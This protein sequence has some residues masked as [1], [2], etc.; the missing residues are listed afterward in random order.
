MK[1]LKV[2]GVLLV[3]LLAALTTGLRAQPLQE[4]ETV[5][6]PIGRDAPPTETAQ[7]GLMWFTNQADFEAFVARQGK[8]L[9]GIEDFEES[10]L[11]PNSAD[12]FD[13]PLE[14]GVANAPDGFPF[15]EGMTGLPNLK[16]QSNFEHDLFNPN[17]PRGVNALAA[18][19]ATAGNFVSDVVIANFTVDS[20][21]LIFTGEETA[22]GFN[23]LRFTSPGAME[24]N[25]FSTTNELLGEMASNSDPAG[26]NFIGVWSPIPIGRINLFDVSNGHEGADRIQAWGAAPPCPAD[27]DDSGDVGV[28]DLLFLLGAWGPCP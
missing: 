21:D 2:I 8:V 4:Q 3:C 28:K 7:G 16:V 1:Q 26:T 10:I 15:P 14:S 6:P 9:K 23:T 12:P 17:N 13:D 25:V 27:F 11:G 20:L 22:V 5:T 19:S 18:F 24:V